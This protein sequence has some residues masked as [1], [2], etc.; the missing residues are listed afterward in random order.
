MDVSNIP[1]T[2]VN[3]YTFTLFFGD[4]FGFNMKKIILLPSRKRKIL[5]LFNFH[6]FLMF[7]LCNY[8]ENRDQRTEKKPPPPFLLRKGSK[9]N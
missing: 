7:L 4:F 9:S 3:M 5:N 8:E 6:N 2:K 1:E